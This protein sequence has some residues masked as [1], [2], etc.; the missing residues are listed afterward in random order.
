MN[1]DTSKPPPSSWLNRLTS[2]M[3]QSDPQNRDELV[4]VLR[5]AQDNSVINTD[6]LPMM[7]GVMQVSD[8]QARDI[9]I[10]RSQMVVLNFGA[11]Y[12]EVLQ[13]IIESNHSRFP[14]I[15]D[16]R[17]DIEGVLLAKEMI[18]LLVKGEIKNKD[19]FDKRDI[20]RQ[21]IVIPE[22]KRLDVLLKEF[23]ARRTHMAIV[24]NEYGGVSGLVTIEDVLEQIVGQIEDEYDFDD[25]D[26]LIKKISDT[27]F[28]LKAQVEIEDFNDYFKVDFAD[29]EFST[30]GGY[31]V[32]A[33]G[34]LPSRDEE[35][36]L[37][38]FKFT[39]LHADNR[40]LNLLRATRIDD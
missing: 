19:T 34:H 7:E 29:D 21:A 37:E 10:P 28:T 26:D 35:I 17:D 32:N 38:P 13:T 36:V 40:R 27:E 22:S 30:I 9:M 14:V 5:T 15:G 12:E 6:A 25:E 18:R 16:D 20:L 33:F 1:E 3:F 11:P 2:K 31:V 4:D 39:V 8:M 23:R 24:V